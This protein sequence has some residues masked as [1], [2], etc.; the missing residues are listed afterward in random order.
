[1][2][3]QTRLPLTAAQHLAALH[4][5]RASEGVAA[6]SAC[7]QAKARRREG[8]AAS[9]H[10]LL[11]RLFC[12]E[13]IIAARRCAMLLPSR[14]TRRDDSC[15]EGARAYCCLAHYARTPALRR[16]RKEAILALFI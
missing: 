9:P 1:M 6:Y 10:L 11:A 2:K 5:P 3:N 8:T 15:R 16:G 7:A 4:S 14:L 12:L 13:G